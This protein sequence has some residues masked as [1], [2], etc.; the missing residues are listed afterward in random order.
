MIN[1]LIL[2]EKELTGKVNWQNIL[3]PAPAPNLRWYPSRDLG[4]DSVLRDAVIGADERINPIPGVIKTNLDTSALD[5]LATTSLASTPSSS[6][7]VLPIHSKTNSS[8][9]NTNSVSPAKSETEAPAQNSDFGT[10]PF[11][12]AT[13]LPFMSRTSVEPLT[14]AVQKALASTAAVKKEYQIVAELSGLYELNEASPLHRMNER[15]LT[16]GAVPRYNYVF[17]P[18]LFDIVTMIYEAYNHIFDVADEMLKCSL[19]FDP[20]PNDHLL[21]MSENEW[22]FLPLWAGGYDDNTGGVFAEDIPDSFDGPSSPQF[23]DRRHHGEDADS[24]F[25]ITNGS[26]TTGFKTSLNVEDGF[27]DHLDRFRTYAASEAMSG[28]ESTS[29][30]SAYEE[31][32]TVDKGKGKATDPTSTSAPTNPA[33]SLTSLASHESSAP[34]LHETMD[35]FMHDDNEQELDLGELSDATEKGGSDHDGFE[36]L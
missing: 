16:Y 29:D 34:V 3:W 17:D 31:A 18:D 28:I 21:C 35:D 9:P 24:D 1:E 12:P 36:L 20:G 15:H 26:Q 23:K 19:S 10:L 22:K 27:S 11:R 13:L 2:E 30:I 32:K 14:H 5:L 4:L 33:G 25:V 7:N 8:A 6:D